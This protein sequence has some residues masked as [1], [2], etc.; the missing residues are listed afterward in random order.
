MRK[1]FCVEKKQRLSMLQQVPL[2]CHWT[3]N[4]EGYV[5]AEYV[6]DPSNRV[7]KAVP[8]CVMRDAAHFSI[9]KIKLEERSP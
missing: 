8:L 2:S 9:L 5:W 3:L 1:I 6:I 4:V 7:Y